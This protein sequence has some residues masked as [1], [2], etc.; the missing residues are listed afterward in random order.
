MDTTYNASPT[1]KQFHLAD[2]FVR[3]IIGPIG[4]GKSVAC[5]WEVF[6]KACQ[7][8]AFEQT[9]GQYKGKMMRKSRWAIIRNTYRELVDTTMQTWFDWFPK[10]LG[11]WR[12][13]DMKF[14]WVFEQQDGTLVHLEVLFRALDRPDDVKKLLSLELTGGWIN[15]ARELPKPILDMLIG[16][17]GRYP[18]KRLGGASWYGVIADTNPPD[19]DHWWYRIFEEQQPDDWACFRQP[20]GVGPNAENKANL[21]DKYYERLS[22]GKDQEWINVYV[23]GKYGFVQDGK[24]IF[25]EYNDHLHCVHD[26]G[27]HESTITIFIGV[28]FGL[29]PAAV[30]AQVSDM[31]GQ[32]QI[33]DEV[34][35]EDMGAVRFGKRIQMLINSNYD[36]LPIDGW[37]DP[38]G[39]Q[40][41]QTDETTPFL[42]MRKAGV[43][44]SP[45][46]TNDFILRRE[47]V[48]K[49][50]TTLTMLGRPQLVIS[51]KARMLRKALAGGYKYKRMN[52]SGGERFSEKADK[53]MY[54]HVADA[55]QY[56]CVGLGHGRDLIRVNHTGHIQTMAEGHDY[57]PLS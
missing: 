46:P 4:S 20:S 32:V 29:T 1:L 53:N 49:L 34:V 43:P 6:R 37:G 24:V 9:A 25:P 42:V 15:E 44:L 16:R 47:S 30:I 36:S 22:S 48:A 12:A 54:S 50:F 38:A 26:L 18:S 14:T 5:C 17:V 45:A 31:D 13:Q 40:R 2:D 41:A 56:L 55:L 27:L 23:H 35:T 7:Q 39:D 8:D 28:D 57:D 10:T 19:E 52:V 33:L 11:L 51:P 21:P 3:G